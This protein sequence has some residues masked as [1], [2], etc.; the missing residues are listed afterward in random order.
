MMMSNKPDDNQIIDWLGSVR[1][2]PGA[3]FY[4]KAAHQPWA[5]GEHPPRK[6]GFF[7]RRVAAIAGLAL[8]L[9]V[10]ISLTSPSLEVLAQRWLQFFLPKTSDQTTVQIPISEISD[11]AGRFTLTIA[12]AEALAGFTARVPAELPSDFRFS[13]AAYEAERGAI[14]LNYMT[15]SGGVLRI[16]QSRAVEEYQQI[17]ASAEVEMVS[18]GGLSGEYLRGAWVIPEVKSA[19]DTPA[20]TTL[21]LQAT[22]NPAANS[23]MLRWQSG[24]MLFEIIV[25]G[26]VEN[27]PGYLDKEDLIALAEQMH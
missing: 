5:A 22:W 18:V 21:P 17:G 15:Q 2:T 23:Q 16:I 27:Q 8:L 6:A 13:G 11:P 19:L 24:E 14:V 12:E 4:Q 3:E 20:K 10:V 25:A 1:P 9:V 7:P 26:G